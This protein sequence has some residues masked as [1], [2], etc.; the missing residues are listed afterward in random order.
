[1]PAF[2]CRSTDPIY[3]VRNAVIGSIFAACR[4]GINPA[5]PHTLNHPERE[6]SFGSSRTKWLLIGP[7]LVLL[8]FLALYGCTRALKAGSH[9]A[10]FLAEDLHAS[11]KQDWNVFTRTRMMVTRRPLLLRDSALMVAGIVR[12]LGVPISCEQGG[13]TKSGNASGNTIESECET[14]FSLDTSGHGLRMA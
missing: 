1:M 3:S 12:K 13:T 14:T 2:L 5:Q 10:Y 6:N 4:A 8:L 11:A 9:E 7:L